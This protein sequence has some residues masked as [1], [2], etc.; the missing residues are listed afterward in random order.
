MEFNPE[1]FQDV[2]RNVVHFP[3]WV[4]NREKNETRKI[5]VQGNLF[6]LN[7]IRP[8]KHLVKQSKRGSRVDTDSKHSFKED[9]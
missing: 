8:L 6:F 3:I 1:G 5:K 7:E 2:W 9:T 4:K